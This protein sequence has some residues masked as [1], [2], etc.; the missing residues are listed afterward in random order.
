MYRFG[1]QNLS[2]LLLLF[3]RPLLTDL[4]LLT[5]AHLEMLMN[6][7]CPYQK[8]IKEG[9]K[10][11]E[12]LINKIN[13]VFLSFSPSYFSSNG[14]QIKSCL[15]C[16]HLFFRRL[17][18]LLL[19]IPNRK[20][21]SVFYFPLNKSLT[22]ETAELDL[23]DTQGIQTLIK[24]RRKKWRRCRNGATETWQRTQD[25]NGGT[26]RPITTFGPRSWLLVCRE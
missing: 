15:N 1:M 21:K 8:Q 16:L 2:L 3:Y 22:K 19:P 14:L 24:Q 20:Q 23:N 9:Y 11:K 17:T 13:D 12:D 7:Y 6:V 5:L 26:F 10:N 4:Y 25:K 18:Q